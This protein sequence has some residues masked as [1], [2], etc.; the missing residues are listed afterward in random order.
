MNELTQ[1][2]GGGGLE[3]RRPSRGIKREG[4]DI[5][6]RTR[7]TALEVDALTA[8]Y[9]R[10]MERTVDLDHHRQ[11]LASNN[12]ELN[13]VLIRLELGFVANVESKLREH[14]SKFGL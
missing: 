6:E 12:P 2:G 3:P 5:V 14:N 1:W 13:A 10:A 11:A 7:K 8:L 9:G 4:R